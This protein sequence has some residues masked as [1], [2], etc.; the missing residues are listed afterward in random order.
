MWSNCCGAES[1]YLSEDICGECLEHATFDD[2][3]G[4]Q[5]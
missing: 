3:D 4:D 5:Y 2:E 1:S